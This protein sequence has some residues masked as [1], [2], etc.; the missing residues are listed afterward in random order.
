MD[1]TIEKNYIP[2]EAALKQK[3][4]ENQKDQKGKPLEPSLSDKW[5]RVLME[6]WLH[7]IDAIKL[8]WSQY[9][10]KQ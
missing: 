2:S 6:K 5:Y 9:R 8:R 10:A 3:E 4:E 1:K 7:F